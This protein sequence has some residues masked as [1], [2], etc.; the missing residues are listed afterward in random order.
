MPTIAIEGANSMKSSR[1]AVLLVA[2]AT[3][4]LFAAD[5]SA[6]YHPS[7]GRF[8]SRDPR[9]ASPA[10]VSAAAAQYADGMNSYQYVRS[11]PLRRTDAFG[12]WGEDI[13]VDLTKELATRAG[14]ACADKV[15]A[16][17]NAP[18]T[19]EGSRPG[20]DGVADAV[21][22][23][24]LGAYPEAKVRLMAIWHFPVSPDGEVHPNSAEARRIMEEGIEECDFKRFSEGL[25][26]IQ[27]SWSHQGK[28][29]IGGIGHGR[30]AYWVVETETRSLPF[31]FSPGLDNVDVITGGHWQEERNTL[32]AAVT[33]S[34]DKAHLWPAD[35]RAA[36]MATYEALLAFKEKCPCHCPGTD[37]SLG[38]TSLREADAKRT[39]EAF[40][41]E[42]FPGPNAPRR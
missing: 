2:L 6:Y 11:R 13:H 38:P 21:W 16:G 4:T 25:H 41:D 12:L 5:L 26:V 9:D 39:V 22:Q 3:M 27:D 7:M 15:A 29:Y 28:P 34:T 30:G 19:Y 36:G 17:A 32:H 33:D 42:T 37:D 31:S 35:V 23:Y 1:P 8:L 24:L 14:F 20:F 18:D 40:L 10:R